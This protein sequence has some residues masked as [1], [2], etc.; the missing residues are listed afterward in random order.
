MSFKRVA[1]TYTMAGMALFGVLLSL[2][3]VFNGTDVEGFF[4]WL[5]I[6]TARQ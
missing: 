6:P 5:G 1:L 4:G 3:V 2:Y